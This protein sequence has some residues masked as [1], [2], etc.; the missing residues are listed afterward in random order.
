MMHL[1]HLKRRKIAVLVSG[2]MMN[3]MFT[4]AMAADATAPQNTDGTNTTSLTDVN[5]NAKSQRQPEVVSRAKQEVAPNLINTVTQEE[6]RKLPDLNAGEAAGR[7]PG[8][9]IAVDTGQGRWVNIRGLDADLTST[10]YGGIHLPPTNSVTPQSPNGGGRAFAFDTFPTGMIGSLTITKTNKPEQDAEALGG[11]I[12]ITPKAIPAGRDG[13]LDFRL[14]TGRQISRG[15]GITD[16]SVTGGIRFGGGG[17]NQDQDQAQDQSGTGTGLKL[18]AYKDKPFSFVGSLTYYKDA[19]GNDDRRASFV[20]K[21]SSPNMAW[22]SMTQAFY[23]FHRTTKGAGGELAYQPDANNRWYARYLHSGY[24]EDVSR[25]RWDFQ[26]KGTSSQSAD[27]S[28]TTGVATF[29]KSLRYMQEQVSLDLFQIGGENRIG[30]A[31]IDYNIAHTQ[32]KD[33]RPYDTIANFAYSP[34]PGT[35]ITYNQ[36]NPSHPTYSV[37]GS[38]QLDPSNYTLNKFT[39]NSATFL[40]KEW[41][42]GT[43]VTMPTHFT[44]ASE[45]ELKFG[46]AARFRSQSHMINSYTATGVPPINMSQ[47][48]TGSPIQ[49]YGGDYSNGYNI[50]QGTMQDL[51]ANGTGFTNNPAKNALSDGAVDQTNTE[52]V[53]ALYGQEDFTFGKLGILAGMR[54]EATRAQYNGNAV[55]NGALV[56]RTANKSYNNLFPSIQARYEIQPT[57]IGRAS[58]SSTISRPSF[59]MTNPSFSLDLNNNIVTQGNPNL[60]PTTSNNLDLSLEQYLNQG[61]IISAG[62][63]DKEMSNYIVG[64]TQVGGLTDPVIISAMASAPGMTNVVS[65]SN[66]AKARATGFELNYDQKYA[67]LPGWLNGLGTSFNY[68]FVNSSGQIRPGE[69]A[70]LPSTSRNTYNASVYWEREK[71]NLRLSGSYVG[72][73][74]AIIGSSAATDIYTEARFSADVSASYAL[75]KNYSLFL[76]GRNLLNTAHTFTEGTGNRVIQREFFGPAVMF[77]ITG[78]L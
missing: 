66:L 74:L 1:K 56:P 68:T 65:Y 6:I 54:V 15:T 18:D 7:L 61:G 70:Q 46:A 62:V 43:N 11:T 8:A 69:S 39:N 58:F 50:N 27:G 38:N 76:M 36:G 59:D 55:L 19:I 72:R 63:F 37:N 41:S 34:P 31:K 13:F 29:D 52:N 44:N 22:S 30:D 73:S 42:T 53:Y 26:G 28:I 24:V 49:Y 75:N 78:S 45:E 35:T 9:S 2:L 21:P 64:T 77:G 12:E 67:R 23:Q 71:L 40:T 4:V 33:Y 16:L 10:T 5:V 14:G 51:F 25:N 60:K 3:T 17:G 20:D 48:I 47:A 32:G 57:L